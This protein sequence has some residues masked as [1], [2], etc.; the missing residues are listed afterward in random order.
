MRHRGVV[1]IS[2]ALVACVVLPACQSQVLTTVVPASPILNCG[3]WNTY[4]FFSAATSADVER[5]LEEGANPNARD[6][7]NAAPL[8]R[9]ESAAVVSVLVKAGAD[10]AAVDDR[11]RTP[12]HRRTAL[13]AIETL[14]QNGADVNARDHRGRTPLHD[15]LSFEH[16]ELLA[17]AGAELEARTDSGETPLHRASGSSSYIRIVPQGSR[18]LRSPSVSSEAWPTVQESLIALGADVKARDK[19]GNTPLE[20]ALETRDYLL[21]LDNPSMELIEGVKGAIATLRAAVGAGE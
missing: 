4:E 16:V 13:D 6:E 15:A 19:W 20:L 18:I 9:A 2:L 12:L 21:D 11:G 7:R 8:H 5:C 3:T 14:L 1:G 17:S 10:V